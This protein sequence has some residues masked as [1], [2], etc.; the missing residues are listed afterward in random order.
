VSHCFK[1]FNESLLNKSRRG[2]QKRNVMS[3]DETVADF[4]QEMQLLKAATIGGWDSRQLGQPDDPFGAVPA[5]LIV[6]L[7]QSI[8]Q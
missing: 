6:G 5:T 1:F 2:Q 7:R 3:V 8:D 4:L